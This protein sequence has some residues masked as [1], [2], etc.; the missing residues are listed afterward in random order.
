MLE[1]GFRVYGSPGDDVL[2]AALPRDADGNGTFFAAGAGNDYIEGGAGGD[3]VYE[4]EGDGIV[5]GRGGRDRLVGDEGNDTLAGNRGNDVLRGA[6][7]HDDAGSDRFVG[8]PD[9]DFIEAVVRSNQLTLP[10]ADLAIDCGRGDDVAKID[11]LDPR[12][13][14]CEDVRER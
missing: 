1:L 3:F 14:S 11:R 10:M 5:R 9:D 8:G 12:P 6:L 2:T 4:G 13:R 7:G